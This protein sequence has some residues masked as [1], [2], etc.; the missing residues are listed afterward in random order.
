MRLITS[1]LVIALGA[2]VFFM[3]PPDAPEAD[4]GI[5][6]SPPPVAVCTVDEGSGRTTDIAILSTVSGPAGVTLFTSGG[7]AGSLK[8][9][10]GGSGSLVIPIVDVAA[11]GTV[12]GLVEMP[13]PTS[14]A[15][16]VIRGAESLTAE[17]C[18]SLPTAQAFIA[19]GTTVEDTAFEVQLMNPYAGQAVVELSV[20]SEAGNE[21]N[22]RFESV[23]VPPR[24]SQFVDFN[25]LT[26]GREWLAVS[27][28]TIT[29]R[30]NAV[31]RQRMNGDTAT[32]RAETGATDWFLPVPKGSGTKEVVIASPANAG[33]DYQIDL[34]TPDGAQASFASG[35]LEERGQIEIDLAEL[36]EEAV[37]LRVISTGP[38]VPTL[39]WTS[40][41]IGISATTGVTTQATRWFMPGA[42]APEGGWASV[43][44]FN[45]GI[46]DAEVRVRP[47]RQNTSVRTLAVGSEE[48][49]ALGLESADGYLI[50]STSPIVVL[51]TAQAGSSTST[52]IGV[53]IADG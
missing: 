51:W 24:S 27:I 25:D 1:L 34:F 28:E 45:P 19:G 41:E 32:W 37:G 15:G 33:I 2:A 11:V 22:S 6:T 40:P 31:A 50:E 46:E 42:S 12:G 7:S 52:A 43:V 14:A 3:A 48:V 5:A 53:P 10:T 23:I 21:S 4:P 35:R 44:L 20:Q 47:L 39:M 13:V 18:A 26:P 38:V 9:T 30:V 49:L 29:G 36:S 17:A 16:S 8:S